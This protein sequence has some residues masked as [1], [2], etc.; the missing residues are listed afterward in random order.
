MKLGVMMDGN[1]I[2]HDSGQEIV[3]IYMFD[4]KIGDSNSYF[5]MWLN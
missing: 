4:E 2:D 1:F 3:R 5:R